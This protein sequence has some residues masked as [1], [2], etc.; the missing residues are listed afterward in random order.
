MATTACVAAQLPRTS[1]LL[2][3][4]L[5]NG[6]A[7]CPCIRPLFFLGQRALSEGTPAGNAASNYSCPAPPWKPHSP[8]IRNSR[9]ELRPTYER[10]ARDPPF[11]KHLSR[12]SAMVLAC[13]TAH[14]KSSASP[15]SRAASHCSAR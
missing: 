5:K 3:W 15:L 2:R 10:V 4:W 9:H 1:A 8:K 14:S 13:W 7:L 12:S 11:E 6:T